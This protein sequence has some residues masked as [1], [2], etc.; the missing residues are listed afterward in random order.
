MLP[1][2]DINPRKCVPFCT[3][4]ILRHLDR[5]ARTP[6]FNE[7]MQLIKISLQ[8]KLQVRP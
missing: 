3:L 2:N 4:Q 6:Y 7:I 1:E 8:V 5:S